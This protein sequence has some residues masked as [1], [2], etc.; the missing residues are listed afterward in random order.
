MPI[1]DNPIDRLPAGNPEQNLWNVIVE[2]PRGCRNKYDWDHEKALFVLK[3]PLFAGASFPY[4]FGFLPQTLAED[5]DPLD[6]LL[7]MDEG[8]Y[9]GCMVESR[10]VGVLTAEQTENGETQRNDRLIAVSTT[11]HAFSN[12]QSL[13]DLSKLV[14]KGM[15]HFFESYNAYKGKPFRILERGTVER[16]VELAREAMKKWEAERPY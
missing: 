6:V 1:H 8:G 5:G 16:A 14:L 2:T 7:L 3:G 15:S 9:P 10:L 11:T 12:V 4:D 13:D